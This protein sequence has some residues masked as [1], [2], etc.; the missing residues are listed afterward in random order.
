LIP[1][2]CRPDGNVSDQTT[3]QS[4][5]RA[6]RDSKENGQPH[7]RRNSFDFNHANYG[8]TSTQDHLEHG[9][10]NLPLDHGGTS[11]H[12]ALQNTLLA[13]VSSHSGGRSPATHLS[14][15]RTQSSSLSQHESPQGRP[16]LDGDRPS[17]AQG[18]AP[19]RRR[20]SFEDSQRPSTANSSALKMSHER[21]DELTLSV[22]HANTRDGL[23]TSDAG[24]SRS[25][26]NAS[27]VITPPKPNRLAKL[28]P[29]PASKGVVHM[30][31]TLDASTT[32]S[33][34]KHDKHRRRRSFG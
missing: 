31:H 25:N 14:S 6:H 12:A 21:V 8:R 29:L 15:N 23:E 16:S 30:P 27:G 24:I 18:Y 1:L 20:S 22:S 33:D 34:H 4:Q 19:R 5:A 32:G 9:K 28:E 11:N 3:A 7:V 2:V 17:T 10:S 26:S 13:G